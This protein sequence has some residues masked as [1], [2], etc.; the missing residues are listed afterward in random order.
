MSTVPIR[1]A[2]P[3]PSPPE[4]LVHPPTPYPLSEGVVVVCIVLNFYV[5]THR[6]PP[7]TVNEAHGPRD[8]AAR[9]PREHEKRK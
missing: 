4:T 6:K 2:E 1:V 5:I 9:T 3:S 8:N 7:F